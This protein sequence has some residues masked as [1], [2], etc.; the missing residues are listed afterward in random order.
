MKLH[1]GGV[2]AGLAVDKITNGSVFDD[3]FGPERVARKTEKICTLIG[4]DF[5]DNIG[6]A[7]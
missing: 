5:D 3:H 4:G 6:P 1:L 7:G 2:V